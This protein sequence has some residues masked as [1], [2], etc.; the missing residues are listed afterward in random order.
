MRRHRY[1]KDPN[2]QGR[3]EE[4]GQSPSEDIH[5]LMTWS[6]ARTGNWLT[7]NYGIY[8]CRPAGKKWIPE[9]GSNPD[10]LSLAQPVTL[11]AA[12]AVCEA[13]REAR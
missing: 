8:R 10:W 5:R 11:A 13:H 9:L 6:K 1:V 4:C 2:D 7:T 12:K 3:C